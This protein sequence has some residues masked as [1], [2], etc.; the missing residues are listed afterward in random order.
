MFRYALFILSWYQNN[1]FYQSF[2]GQ[3]DT[4]PFRLHVGL[5]LSTAVP[6]SFRI[7]VNQVNFQER[8][9][10]SIFDREFSSYS[11]ETLQD[12]N[13]YRLPY[14]MDGEDR[15]GF[16]AVEQDEGKTDDSGNPIDTRVIKFNGHVID[17][18]RMIYQIIFS[19]DTLA[20]QASYLSGDWMDFVDTD[21][22]A[23]VETTLS[24][25]AY[26]FYLEFREPITDP[27]E[28]LNEHIY[29]P[30]AIFPRVN[31]QG[32]LALKLH[33][34]PTSDE[35]VLTLHEGNII[36]VDSK[37]ITDENVVNHIQVYYGWK[38][39][40][41]EPS[42]M[43]YFGDSASYNKFRMFIPQDAPQTI[44]VKGINNLSTT[45]R[46]TFAQNLVDSIFARYA[47]PLVEM[48]VTV[49]LE[50]VEGLIVGDYIFIYHDHV[51]AWEDRTWCCE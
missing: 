29:K 32:K 7:S 5:V 1:T 33:A 26:N 44:D 4:R 15:K 24:D 40:E 37:K 13:D 41:D 48:E 22:L 38:F 50:V 39:K 43:R 18:V 12:I 23:T 30:C 8:L 20:V 21:S 49:P 51:V 28:F 35:D 25:S 34:Q 36:S 42:T 16:E 45:D 2:T 9:K 19:T 27:Y 17:F 46:G 47:L 31:G 3:V 11:T 10:T 14:Y 6:V